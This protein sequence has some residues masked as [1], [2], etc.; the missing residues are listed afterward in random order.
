MNFDEKYLFGNVV[1][2]TFHDKNFTTKFYE[3]R[4]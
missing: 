3:F 1:S 2:C 4:C